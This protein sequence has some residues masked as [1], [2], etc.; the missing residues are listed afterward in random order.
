M[1]QEE[2]KQTLQQ[3]EELRHHVQAAE[4]ETA[5]LQ[6]Q[7]LADLEK[8]QDLRVEVQQ[9]LGQVL[10]NVC[11]MTN[12]IMNLLGLFFLNCISVGD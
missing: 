5:Q 6:I 4:Q 1:A 11:L 10:T 8:E 3:L 12:A 7:L 2:R 9:E